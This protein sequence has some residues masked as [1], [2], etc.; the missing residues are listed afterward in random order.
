MDDNN[1]IHNI[2]IYN[3]VQFCFR[4]LAV[5]KMATNIWRYFTL[6]MRDYP[7]HVSIRLSN[8]YSILSSI[9]IYPLLNTVLK[10]QCTSPLHTWKRGYNIL[11]F[12]IL[13]RTPCRDKVMGISSPSRGKHC[14]FT[15]YLSDY[16][17][18]SIR[19]FKTHIL[20]SIW[21]RKWFWR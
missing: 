4:R 15:G 9:N 13:K 10:T 8:I 19:N 21:Y 1:L 18:C 20:H 16:E 14:T 2:N 11:I 17:W 7:W 12:N 5:D 3:N 6:R